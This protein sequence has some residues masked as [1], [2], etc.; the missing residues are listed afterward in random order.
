[1]WKEHLYEIDELKRGIGLRAYGQRDP[2][3]EYK[4]ES[5]RMFTELLEKMDEETIEKVF[6][7]RVAERPAVRRPIR[8]PQLQLVHQEATGLGYAT[9]AV[10]D[11]LSSGVSEPQEAKRQPIRVAQKVGRNDPCPCGS[12]KKYKKCHGA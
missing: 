3:I 10:G 8:E 12:G 2:L 4:R 7:T 6:K 11:A 5:F 1:L 9:A